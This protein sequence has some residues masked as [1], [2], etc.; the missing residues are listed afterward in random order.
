MKKIDFHVHV[1][2]S[3]SPER[4]AQYLSD[5]CQR[6]GYEGVGIMSLYYNYGEFCSECNDIALRVKDLLKNS[7]AFAS[8]LP[9]EDFALQTK[10]LMSSGFDGIK[11][12]RG[13]KPSHHRISGHSYDS[14][15]YRDFFSYAEEER[16]PILMHNNDPALNW[17]I[18][19]ASKRAIEKGWVYDDTYPSH[20]YYYSLVDRVLKKHPLLNLT[21]AHLGFYS[22]NIDRA[23][24]L[25]ERY[26]NLR[27]DVTPALNI[28]FELSQY[29]EKAKCFFETYRDRLIFG[30]DADSQLEGF[31]RDYNDKKNRITSAFLT[32]EYGSQQEFE[33]DVIRPIGLTNDILADIYYNNAKRFLATRNEVKK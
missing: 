22:E 19:R 12:I 11:L 7:Y 9:N 23:I 27:F 25:L 32:G 10:R 1:S 29:P 33:G 20:E 2:A 3:I 8:L 26:P 6:H 21:I 28:Y 15:I 31:A 4:S 18:K 16:V 13:G 14:E 17:D 30:T 5:M 24:A